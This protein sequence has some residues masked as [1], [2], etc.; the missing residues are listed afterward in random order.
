MCSAADFSKP[1]VNPTR[2]GGVQFEWENGARYFEIEIAAE[3]AASFFFRNDESSVEEDG[4]ILA[5][6]SLEPVLEYV[7]LVMSPKAESN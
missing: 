4:S 5:S 6:E 7:R 1:H 3:G 2:D